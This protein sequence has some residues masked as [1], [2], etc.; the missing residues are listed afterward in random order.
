MKLL[1]AFAAM[2]LSGTLLAQTS[3]SQA[4]ISATTGQDSVAGVEVTPPAHPITLEQ[5]REMFALMNFDKMMDELMQ[6]MI[7]KQSEQ[8]P[9]IPAAVWDDMRDTFRKTDF[10]AAFLPVYQK[11]ISEEDAR[12]SLA[13]YK[14]PAGQHMLKA[15]PPMMME[16]SAIGS[17]KG[18][19]IAHQVFER[20]A[21][22][23][24]E[25]ARK[26]QEQQKQPSGT[27][28]QSPQSVD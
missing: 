26:Y 10:I 4:P 12:A 28:P 11:Y 24:K 8:A 25:A 27:V 15:M 21:D 17:Q 5:T 20:H 3:S 7:A 16:V 14:T 1:I 13:F 19:D 2:L 23:I 18:Q 6:Q 9:F 22:E